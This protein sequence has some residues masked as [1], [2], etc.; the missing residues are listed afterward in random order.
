M[1]YPP[2]RRERR[3]A[4]AVS[5]SRVRQHKSPL[6]R[7]CSFSY[8]PDILKVC[9]GKFA[10]LSRLALGERPRESPNP[11]RRRRLRIS[12]IFKL[13]L[14]LRLVPYCTLSCSWF[15]QSGG[16]SPCIGPPVPL[17]IGSVTRVFSVRSL[18]RQGWPESHRPVVTDFL[19]SRVAPNYHCGLFA[20]NVPL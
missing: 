19:I 17:Q 7:H 1:T 11:E 15:C 5:R 16:K 10:G 3:F 14:F 6:N 4:R 20:R 18:R 8:L 2:S 12:H 9:S 13:S